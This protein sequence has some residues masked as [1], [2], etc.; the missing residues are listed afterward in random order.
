[1]VLMHLHD[2]QDGQSI[3]A[4]PKSKRIVEVDANY[5]GPVYPEAPKFNNPEDD[6]LRIGMTR[7]AS[8]TRIELIR[9]RKGWIPELPQK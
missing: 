5:F 4:K 3:Q 2:V 6:L 1:M 9:S 8:L 7:I